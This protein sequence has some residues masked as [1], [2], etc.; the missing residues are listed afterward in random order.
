M[1][2]Q[3]LTELKAVTAENRIFTDEPM[4]KHTTFRVGGPA[5]IL[6]QPKGTELA[7]VIRLCRKYDVPYQVIGNGSNLLVGDRGIRGLVIEML[8]KEDEICVEDDCITVGAGMLLSKTANRAAEHGLTGMEFAAGIPG[9]IGGAVVMNAGAYGGEMKDILT[10]VTV[11]DQE[12]NEK[13]LSAEELELGYRTSCILKKGYIVT[14]AKIKLKHGEETAIRARMEELKKQ[15]VEKQPLE[16][17]SAGSTFKR[18]EGYFA[19]KLIEDAGLKGCA[20]GGAQV[21]EK[22]AGFV[23]NKGDATAK[24]VCELTDYIKS[25]VM[26]KFGVGLELEV[27]KVG[28]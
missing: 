9:S 8:S 28:F 7:S 12:G 20:R 16:Y 1:N 18:P 14:G 23:V 3:F 25:E 6:V 11:L 15:R 27:V 22:H 13:I 4:K 24:D 26:E 10:A 5:D 19:A 17:P 21:S 2:Q